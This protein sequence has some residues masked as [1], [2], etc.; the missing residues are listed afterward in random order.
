MRAS[1]ARSRS[2]TSVTCDAAQGRVARSSAVLLVLIGGCF[3]P[4]FDRPTCPTGE[5]PSGLTCN[6][7]HQCVCAGACATTITGGG[8]AT[9]AGDDATAAWRARRGGRPGRPRRAAG[10][11]CGRPSGAAAEN[12]RTQRCR[13]VVV[14]EGGLEPPRCYPLAPQASAST[15]SAIRA[16]SCQTETLGSAGR[17]RCQARLPGVSASRRARSAA[18]AV[19]TVTSHAA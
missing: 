3:R 13:C 15:N 12:E 2:A 6:T 17:S 10:C 19:S 11:A 1:R 16:F 18:R 5:C 4:Q 9:S 14:R 8:G 7:D